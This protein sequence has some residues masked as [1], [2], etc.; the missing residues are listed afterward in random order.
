MRQGRASRLLLEPVPGCET[1]LWIGGKDGFDAGLLLGAKR[2]VHL[3]VEPAIEDAADMARCAGQCVESGKLI[4]FPHQFLDGDVD[5]VGQI[6]LRLGRLAHGRRHG[7]ARFLA[8]ALDM[9]R[10]ADD[11]QMPPAGPGEVVTRQA[12]KAGP[13]LGGHGDVFGDAGWNLAD[14]HKI[15]QALKG[16]QQ[17]QKAQAGLFPASGL[18]GQ[19]QLGRGRGIDGGQVMCGDVGLQP[20]VCG[21]LDRRQGETTSKERWGAGKNDL[22]SAKKTAVCLAWG[23]PVPKGQILAVLI[24]FWIP[25]N[26]STKSKC[27]TPTPIRVSWHERLTR[28]DGFHACRLCQSLDHRPEP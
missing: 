13:G 10:L 12:G 4:L 1:G 8:V 19:G 21:F 25:I 2:C 26:R 11:L 15:S 5:E 3:L 16:L 27:Q 17:N 6:L 20:R 24:H 22:W 18:P 28:T 9:E 7:M 23:L 14:R